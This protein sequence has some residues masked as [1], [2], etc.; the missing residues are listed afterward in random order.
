MD[1]IGASPDR[2]TDIPSGERDQLGTP[3]RAFSIFIYISAVI[4]R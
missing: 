4:K 3:L 1:K 2:I